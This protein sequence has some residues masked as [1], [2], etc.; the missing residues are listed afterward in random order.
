MGHLE[1]S[2]KTTALL[3][4][5]C[6]E[7]IVGSLV[8]QEKEKLITNLT[9]AIK[10]A[11]KASIAIIYVIVQ[12]REGYPEISERNIIFKSVK[13]NNRLREDAPDSKICQEF[14]PERGDI[15]VIKKR[16]S[17][18]SGSDLEGILR[19][20]GIDTIVL[21]GVSSLGVVESTARFAFDM[22]YKIIILGDCCS[23]KD[24]EAHNIT[25]KW[26]F[27]RIS[28]VSSVSDFESAISL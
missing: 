24:L 11:R 20:R 4:M 5:D 10:A 13:E 6:Q 15:V 8:P 16:I 28:T 3:L 1:I 23:D 12:F 7:G 2:S 17:A 14:S 25:L 18:F 22:D 19:A 27:P 26:L 9:R 21:T